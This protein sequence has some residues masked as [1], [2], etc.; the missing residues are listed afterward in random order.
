MRL[1]ACL[2]TFALLLFATAA[3]PSTDYYSVV[4]CCVFHRKH[5]SIPGNAPGIHFQACLDVWQN[6]CACIVRLGKMLLYGLQGQQEGEHG[7]VLYEREG[8][9]FDSLWELVFR[10]LVPYAGTVAW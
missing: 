8:L 3:A 7:E 2:T 4:P 1:L 5:P 10:F 6:V 9:L